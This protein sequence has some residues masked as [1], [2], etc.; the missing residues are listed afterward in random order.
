V[1]STHLPN[2]WHVSIKNLRKFMNSYMSGLNWNLLYVKQTHELIHWILCDF[3]YSVYV[4]QLN[5][6][7]MKALKSSWTLCIGL[8]ILCLISCDWTVLTPVEVPNTIC[9][10]PVPL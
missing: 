7:R 2:I 3:L 1:D 5:I 6:L 4:G 10:H 9:R 8:R